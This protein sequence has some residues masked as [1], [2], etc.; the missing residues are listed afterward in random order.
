MKVLFEYGVDFI[1][2]PLLPPTIENCKK[3]AFYQHPDIPGGNCVR[4]D[5]YICDIGRN[6]Y[7]AKIICGKLLMSC[8]M[9]R[10]KMEKCCETCKFL[11]EYTEKKHEKR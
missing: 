8:H 6:G 2:L 4:T 5:S 10:V 9:W 11:N 3:C 1:N 7:F